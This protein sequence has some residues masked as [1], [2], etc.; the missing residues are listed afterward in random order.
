MKCLLEMCE[1]GLDF[2]S[3]LTKVPHTGADPGWGMGGPCPPPPLFRTEQAQ[4]VE[5][6]RT[7]SARSYSNAAHISI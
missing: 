4:N 2:M 3:A 6:Y 7:L 1:T 5:V